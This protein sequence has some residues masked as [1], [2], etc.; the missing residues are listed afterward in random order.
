M[1]EGL[2]GRLQEIFKR[3]RGQGRLTEA[4]V[5]EAAREIRKAL[6]EADVHF[7]VAKDFVAEVSKKASGT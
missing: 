5:V 3:L 1:F 2:S 6:L 7:K 4:N